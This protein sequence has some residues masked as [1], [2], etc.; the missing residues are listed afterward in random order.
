[1]RRVLRAAVLTGEAVAQ[2]HVETGEGH[3]PRHR[4][5]VPKRDDRG[6]PDGSRWAPDGAVILGDDRHL[7]LNHEA[8]RLLPSEKREREIAQRPEVGVEHKRGMRGHDRPPFLGAVCE[9][10]GA[11]GYDPSRLQ[12]SAAPVYKTEPHASADAEW[13]ERED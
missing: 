7:V 11:L 9:M 10:V 6:Q 13:S 12:R 8:H 1:M 3:A 5:I 2:E 4:D